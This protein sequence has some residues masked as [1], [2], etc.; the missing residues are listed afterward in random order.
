MEMANRAN[1]C[2][3][4]V[5]ECY[6]KHFG[7][8]DGTIHVQEKGTGRT[9]HSGPDALCKE[10]EIYTLLVK[11]KRNFSFESINNDIESALGPILKELRGSVDLNNN[12]VRR[13]IFTH[14]AALT[15]NLIARSRVLRAYTDR[16]LDQ[17]NEFL[18][19]H[20]DFFNGFPEDE[21]QKFLQKPQAFPELL[22]KFPGGTKYL[23]IVRK[24]S[25]QHPTMLGV[26]DTI[27]CLKRVKA[28]H[29]QVLLKARTRVAA[30]LMVEIGA[31]ADLLTTDMPRFIS[32]DDPVV[33]L[34]EGVRETRIV[35]SDV[36]HWTNSSRDVYLPLNPNTAI[37]WNTKGSYR[38]R[39][40]SPEDVRRYNRMVKENAI[41]HV[42]ASD[43]F[44][45]DV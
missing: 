1:V 18:L 38:S 8:E 29:H 25:E 17:I 42:F 30:D 15:A 10:K 12:D 16:S 43:R 35:P 9:F 36:R 28:I 13:R 33:F 7:G 3:H 27:E 22:N 4:V 19:G 44:D 41:R 23:S 20:P 5:P 24:R 26:H 45:F 21:Y 14:L 37:L 32:G 40:V 6:L 31:K 11:G 39:Q 2:Q 34:T